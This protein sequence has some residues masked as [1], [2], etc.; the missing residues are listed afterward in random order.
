MC[1][2]RGGAGR[3]DAVDE[4][5]GGEGVLDGEALAQELGVP[6]QVRAGH[7][8]ELGAQAAGGAGGDGG[9]ADDEGRRAAAGGQH[10][11]E[12]GDGGLE[13]AQVGAEAV[14]PLRGAE[15]QEV[16]VGVGDLGVVGGE[17]EASG[18]QA[19]AEDL[20]EAGLV[21]GGTARLHGRDAA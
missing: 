19:A 5:V 16:H 10:C 13:G 3:G 4:T 11:G 2:G 14:G 20:L 1:V 8:G 9:L 17:A 12:G 21:E 18:G 7:R 15:A 6:H